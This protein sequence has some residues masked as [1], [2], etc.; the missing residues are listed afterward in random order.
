[1]V[2]VLAEAT[3]GLQTERK[4]KVFYMNDMVLMCPDTLRFMRMM[5]NDAEFWEVVRALRDSDGWLIVPFK[6]PPIL[7]PIEDQ[8]PPHVVCL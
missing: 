5:Y 6:D 1:M 7:Y 3:R 8:M 2:P 4:H